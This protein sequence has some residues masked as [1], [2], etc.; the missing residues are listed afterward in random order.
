MKTKSWKRIAII[1]AIALAA[2]AGLAALAIFV[3]AP[4]IRYGKAGSLQS[5]GDAA[6]AYEAYDRMGGYG[7]AQANKEKLQEEVIASRSADSMDF[8]GYTWL[9]LE[10]RDGKTLLLLRDAL[11]PQPYN[12][13]LTASSW[14]SCTLRVYLNEIFYNSIP[15][16]DRARI[17][18]TAVLNSSNAEN[19]TKAGSDT[20]DHVFLLSLAQA[21]LYFPDD[22][23]RVARGGRGAHVGWW[24]RSPGM[25]PI[26]A[27]IVGSDGA[28]GYYGT[29]VNAANRYVRPAMWIAAAEQ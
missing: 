1:G 27:A 3:A 5:R 8:G 18:E 19:G 4:A 12:E 2:A 6:G 29:G 24:L 15:E 13:A 9:I 25:E 20:V 11:D 26:T 14:E 10:E 22:A 7:Q 16:A 21:K 23:A 17:A 28:V